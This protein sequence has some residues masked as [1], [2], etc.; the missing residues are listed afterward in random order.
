MICRI[1]NIQLLWKGC[2]THLPK[3][4]HTQAKNCFSK[5]SIFKHFIQFQLFK[6]NVVYCFYIWIHSFFNTMRKF[7]SPLTVLGTQ[8]IIWGPNK[9]NTCLCL[10]SI[11]PLKLSWLSE[12]MD[13]CTFSSCHKLTQKY[14][15]QHL[16]STSGYHTCERAHTHV[17]AR[18]QTKTCAYIYTFTHRIL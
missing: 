12:K 9:I 4:C 7:L 6:K 1:P 8:K 16:T 15:A 11:Q 2:S 17:H 14:S 10:T 5:C 13:P 18:T 3:C